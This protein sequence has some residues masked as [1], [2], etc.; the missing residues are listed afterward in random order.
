MGA[1]GS[2][3][4]PETAKSEAPRSPQ[5]IHTQGGHIPGCSYFNGHRGLGKRDG[6]EIEDCVL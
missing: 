3:Q 5:Y 2:G 6:V 1:V 4:C